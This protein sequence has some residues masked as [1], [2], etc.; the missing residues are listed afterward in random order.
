MIV[1]EQI[2]DLVNGEI[3]TIQ[4]PELAPVDDIGR[5][6]TRRRRRRSVVGSVATIVVLLALVAAVGTRIRPQPQ[7]V[8]ADTSNPDGT[9]SYVH[10]RPDGTFVGLAL[11]DRADSATADGNPEFV[12]VSSLNGSDWTQVGD[13]QIFVGLSFMFTESDG[14]VHLVGTRAAAAAN[15]QQGE[16]WP[17]DQPLPLPDE[18]MYATSSDLEDWA[19]RSYPMPDD[20][21]GQMQIVEGLG[22]LGD[23]V[24]ALFMGFP[25]PLTRLDDDICSAGR[26]GTARTYRV[27]GESEIIREPFEAEFVPSDLP[28]GRIT[29]LRIDSGGIGEIAPPTWPDLLSNLPRPSLYETESGIGVTGY[30]AYETTTGSDWDMLSV[31]FARNTIMASRGEERVFRVMAPTFVSTSAGTEVQGSVM[32]YSSDGGAT[33][34]PI[35]LEMDRSLGEPQG[36]TFQSLQAGGAGWV[37]EVVRMNTTSVDGVRV[38]ATSFEIQQDGYVLSGALPFGAAELRDAAGEVVRSWDVFE[39]HNPLWSGLEIDGL[40]VVVLDEQTG[41]R[42]VT[43]SPSQWQ[44]VADRDF[45]LVSELLFSANG[46]DWE[47]ID[48]AAAFSRVL[49]IGNEEVIVQRFLPGVLSHNDAVI[50]VISLSG[51]DE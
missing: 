48:T 22:A 6:V 9:P 19:E 51:S 36:P 32:S 28:F 7:D 40:D 13:G 50:D 38:D 47:I 41:N 1:D 14:V 3:H 15:S 12:L 18:I 24:A 5:T 17:V 46:T 39:V 45:P 25:Q 23:G 44:A 27:C 37:A 42:L 20:L 16:R 2:R 8:F 26:D 29:L 21:A 43:F 4:L 35:K 31:G 10:A 34:E 30:Q 11:R 49:A 33:W